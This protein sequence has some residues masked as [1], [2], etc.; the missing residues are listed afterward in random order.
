MTLENAVAILENMAAAKVKLANAPRRSR[1]L[2]DLGKRYQAE[3]DAI[4]TVIA[5]L[6]V[7][8]K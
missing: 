6:P 2:I 8:V 4:Q 5:A 7:G 1:Y 3:A